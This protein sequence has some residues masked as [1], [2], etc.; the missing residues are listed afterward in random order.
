[1]KI[2]KV[3]SVIL[4]L[5]IILLGCVFLVH[6]Q[7]G[8]DAFVLLKLYLP[9]IGIVLM[10]ITFIWTVWRV[11]KKRKIAQPLVGFLM[12]SIMGSMMLTNLG[13]QPYDINSENNADYGIGD[14]NRKGFQDKMDRLYHSMEHGAGDC[15]YLMTGDGSRCYMNTSGVFKE[16]SSYCNASITKLYTATVIHQLVAEG[17]I[18][19]EDKLLKYF[20]EDEIVGIHTRKGKDY[21]KE[22]TVKQLMNQTSGIADFFTEKAKGEKSFYDRLLLEGDLSFSF[23]NACDRCRKIEGHFPPGQ[24]RKA[25]YSDMNYHLLGEII[26]RKTG[27]SLQDNFSERIFKPLGLE[28]TYLME[29]EKWSCVP[30]DN[31]GKE[32][33][34]I[35]YLISDGAAGGIITTMQDSMRF[36]QAFCKGELFDIKKVPD[37]DCY[38]YIQFFPMQYGMGKMRFSMPGAPKAVGH[39]GATGA[40]AY[41]IEKYD[42][43]A[44]GTTN[45]L[46]EAGSIK[47][48]LRMAEGFR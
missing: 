21:A 5:L 30:V 34:A 33:K 44:V 32:L 39:S 48:M 42:V 37:Y 12:S 23:S 22:I 2:G 40:F 13:M 6:G 8:G 1:M 14:A 31:K 38:R 4:G 26:I 19:Y 24:G 10:G 43:Y 20:A 29:E 36:I 45:D 16:N 27:K 17:K 46:N 7:V 25:H 35:H 15:F 9:F 11:V 41:Y 47:K 18:T 3:N 28:N